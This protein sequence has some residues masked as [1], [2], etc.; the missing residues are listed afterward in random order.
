M[1]ILVDMLCRPG[2]VAIILVTLF[3]GLAALSIRGQSATWDEPLHL[4]AGLSYLQSVI[5]DSIQI[6]LHSREYGRHFLLGILPI[7]QCRRYLATHGLKQTYWGPAVRI[8]M[9]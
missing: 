2:Y 9:K 5:R 8:L 4:T 3:L 6:T 1:K 7:R